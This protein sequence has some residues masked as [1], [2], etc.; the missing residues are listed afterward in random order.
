MSSYEEKVHK[1]WEEVGD[2]KV[3]WNELL[4]EAAVDQDTSEELLLQCGVGEKGMESFFCLY[5][6]LLDALTR[7]IHLRIL[8]RQLDESSKQINEAEDQLVTITE[9]VVK[10]RQAIPQASSDLRNSVNH[11]NTV[12]VISQYPVLSKKGKA[13]YSA[14]HDNSGHAYDRQA[15]IEYANRLTS[16]WKNKKGSILDELV[17]NLK[18]P[19]EAARLPRIQATCRT[20]KQVSG[21]YY[22]NYCSLELICLYLYTM[23]APDVDNMMGYKAPIHSQNNS[24][25]W[26]S[27]KAKN[28]VVFR[29]VNWAMRTAVDREESWTVIE[30]WVKFIVLLIAMAKKSGKRSESTNELSRGLAGLPISV[31]TDHENMKL[32][33]SLFWPA[34]SSCSLDPKISAD[35][36][37]GAAAN[38]TKS[39]EEGNSNCL[40]YKINESSHGVALHHVSRYPEEAEILLSPLSEF[41]VESVT[42]N[43]TNSYLDVTLIN[44]GPLSCPALDDVC[45][46][47]LAEASRASQ[48]VDSTPSDAAVIGIYTA[49]VEHLQRWQYCKAAITKE[50]NDQRDLIASLED[51]KSKTEIEEGLKKQRISELEK[52]LADEMRKLSAIESKNKQ[53]RGELSSQNSNLKIL[54]VREENAGDEAASLASLLAGSESEVQSAKDSITRAG[55]DAN[56]EIERQKRIVESAKKLFR[57]AEN[58][59]H[60]QE[61]FIDEC[62]ADHSKLSSEVTNLEALGEQE[63]TAP[64]IEQEIRVCEQRFALKRHEEEHRSALKVLTDSRI[65]Q[66]PRAKSTDGKRAAS[67]TSLPYERSP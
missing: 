32:G 59:K 6:I 50:V 67:V 57:D 14:A 29:A 45:S 36:V 46:E 49:R 9:Q 38:A 10:K 16:L 27:Y 39:D 24:E 42:K 62:K 8:K 31:V 4:S 65:R 52:Q 15:M 11:Q 64:L 56:R 26:N 2:S 54:S 47:A 34:P 44:K 48:L 22:K 12:S 21:N 25:E 30:K 43:P 20:L 61:V 58:D 37:A 55:I 5:P 66:Q 13:P 63:N 18:S 35:Y 40:L 7:I 51:E 41:T 33:S 60:N 17:A 1:V 53:L 28:P 23:A 3:Q 19:T